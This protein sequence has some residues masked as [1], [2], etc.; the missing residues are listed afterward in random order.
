[1]SAAFDTFA[2]VDWSSGNDTG[3][4]PRKDAIWAASVTRGVSEDPAN[5]RNRSLALSWITELIE[6]EI[7]A[8]RHLL[9]GFDF[10]FGYP[11]GF[12]HAVNGR[13]DPLSLWAWFA[14]NLK[15][16]PEG[17]NRFDLAGQL[18]ARFPGIGPFWF[19]ALKRD[20][21]HLPRKGTDRADH[22]MFERRKAETQAKGSF[23]CW[24]MGGAGAV[25]GQVMTGLATLERLRGRFPD[26]IAVWPFQPLDTPVAFVEIWPSLIDPVVREVDDIRDRAQVNLLAQTL[27]GLEP[28]SLHRMLDAGHGNNEEGWILGLGFEEA[29]QAEAR[30]R[31]SHTSVRVP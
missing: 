29:L 23:T 10:P 26:D 21:P 13:A 18:N 3:P 12:A 14:E 20:I 5:L 22:G 31:L 6:R 8:G 28:D 11:R 27:A 15:D 19:N 24:Q 17:N 1:M 30:A 25:G 9:I 4:M 16:A 7:A 2:V